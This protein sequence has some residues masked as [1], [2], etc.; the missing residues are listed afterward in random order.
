MN[1]IDFKIVMKNFNSKSVNLF[2]FCFIFCQML[3]SQ[4]LNNQKNNNRI[5]A[6]NELEIALSKKSVNNFSQKETIIKDSL[7]AIS[8]AETI[9][10]NIFDKT[11]ILEQKPYDIHHINNYWIIS[12][13][14]PKGYKG[15]TFLIIIDDRNSEVI[16][17]T[18]GK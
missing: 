6:E 14:L 18:H 16:R 4:N 13:I 9:L 10:F 7:S 11:S 15:G 12:G 17:I 1:G 5:I 3:T 2:L 8:I